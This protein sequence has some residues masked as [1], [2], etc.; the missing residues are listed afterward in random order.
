MRKLFTLVA[1]CALVVAA[2]GTALA[3]CQVPC[4]IYDDPA[5]IAQM[6]ED[7]ATITK[8]ITNIN[9]L[10]MKQDAESFNQATR[11]VNTKEAHASNIIEIVSTYFLTQKLKPV[12]PGAEGYDEYVAALVDHHAVMRAAMK[13]KQ[14][15][16][17]ESASALDA[18]IEK[19]ATHWK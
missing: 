7:A 12:A 17:P 1:A 4:G 14:G 10:V 9:T 19:L 2:A 13:T 18:A 15:S 11:W 8:A 6:R 3:H 5:R 16:S